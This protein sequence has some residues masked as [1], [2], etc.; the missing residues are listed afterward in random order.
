M[1]PFAFAFVGACHSYVVTIVFGTF[2]PFYLLLYGTSFYYYYN[3]RGQVTVDNLKF[4]YKS[5]DCFHAHIIKII[6]KNDRCTIAVY[7]GVDYLRT[8]H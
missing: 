3:D 4:V 7:Y 2:C 5:T 8:R 1:D 6:Q